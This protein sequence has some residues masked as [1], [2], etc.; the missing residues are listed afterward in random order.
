M[1]LKTKLLSTLTL[2]LLAFNSYSIYASTPHLSAN[3]ASWVDHEEQIIRAHIPNI[4]PT[5]L[6]TSL[7]AYNHAKSMGIENKPLLTIIDFSKPSSSKRLWV[8]NLKNNE[9]LF[10]TYVSHGKNSGGVDSTSFSNQPQSKKSSI[11]VYMTADTYF[12]KNGYSLR[13]RGLDQGYNN[14]VYKRDIVMH[15]AHYVGN[16]EIGHSWGCPAIDPKLAKPI[17]NTIKQNTL[18]V[19]YYPDHSWLT[20]SEF[21]TG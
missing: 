6:R 17:I 3:K 21:L 15:G 13:L 10:N 4:N 1:N 9:E 16:G 5:A 14:N 8:I 20:H 18:I 11:G 2:S 12:G 7:I 19:A